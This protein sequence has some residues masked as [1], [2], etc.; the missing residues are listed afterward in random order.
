MLF[1]F[2]YDTSV[3]F[4]SS[5]QVI[6]HYLLMIP[7]GQE[8]DGTKHNEEPMELKGSNISVKKWLSCIHQSK[9]LEFCNDS[10]YKLIFQTAPKIS[11]EHLVSL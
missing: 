8:E 9:K 3:F 2:D 11:K 10:L 6:P 4:I 1:R 5:N 7:S